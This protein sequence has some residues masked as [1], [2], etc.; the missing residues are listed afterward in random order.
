MVS[1]SNARCFLSLTVDLY[2]CET[3]CLPKILV[4]RFLSLQHCYK[5]NHSVV[6]DRID[7]RKVFALLHKVFISVVG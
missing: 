3:A 5:Y 1:I 2:L 7:Y 6:G 4:S